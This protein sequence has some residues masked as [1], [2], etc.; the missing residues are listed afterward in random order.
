[1]L[2]LFA[3]EAAQQKPLAPGAVRRFAF[4]AVL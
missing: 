2:D 4:R 3:D 1:M